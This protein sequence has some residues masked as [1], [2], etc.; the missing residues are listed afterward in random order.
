ML[1]LEELRV[2]KGLSQAE[3]A[4]LIDVS[5]ST[6]GMYEQGRRFPEVNTLM[7][8]ADF[9]NVPIDYLLGRECQ[10]GDNQDTQKKQAVKEESVILRNIKALCA[11]NE[12]SAS[13]LEQA[14]GFG[15]GTIYK[16]N[17]STPGVDKLKKVA[18]YLEV[19]VDYFLS[20]Q[21]SE[22]AGSVS[23]YEKFTEL[24][25]AK[26]VTAY[27]VSKETGIAQTTISSWKYGGEPKADKLIKLADYFGV[28]VNYFF[29]REPQVSEPKAKPEPQDFLL[30]IKK[31]INEKFGDDSNTTGGLAFIGL[32]TIICHA[33]CVGSIDKLSAGEEAEALDM[34]N[35]ILSE[36]AA[37]RARNIAKKG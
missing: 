17:N 18:D 7:K 23:T 29:G 8:L 10:P 24:L 16:W 5:P 35:R 2:A 20:E 22:E 1:R 21:P 27:R 37:K 13:Q 34:A 3:L 36:M 11:A 25:K 9:F 31:I 6:I 15:E 26:G 33:Y 32:N 14:L 30:R 4:N 19:P 12:T 28:D